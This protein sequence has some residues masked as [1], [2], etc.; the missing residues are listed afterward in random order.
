MKVVYLNDQKA[1]LSG[2][3]E[4]YFKNVAIWAHQ[5]CHSFVNY[6]VTEVSDVSP[7]WDYI[8]EFRFRDPNDAVLFELKWS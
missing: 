3:P 7:I 6:T 5:H 8:A 1:M 2:D 4:Q